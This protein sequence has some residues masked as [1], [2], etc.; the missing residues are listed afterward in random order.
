MSYGDLN[1]DYSTNISDLN[2]YLDNPTNFTE[3]DLSNVILNWNVSHPNLIS[4]ISQL[5]FI[6][7]MDLYATRNLISATNGQ[8]M[9]IATLGASRTGVNGDEYVYYSQ[10]GGANW[11]QSTVN[12]A[13]TLGQPRLGSI[14]TT[15]QYSIF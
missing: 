12:T 2:L 8:T 5:N 6:S 4:S 10:D 3:T 7:N 1:S 9:A 14:T 13:K 15:G 11:S